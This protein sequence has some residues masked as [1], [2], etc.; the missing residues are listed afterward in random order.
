[1]MTDIFERKKS[2]FYH[3]GKLMR[4]NKI[5][6]DDFKEYITTRLPLN[7]DEKLYDIVEE[8][9]AF[10]NLHPYYTQQLSAQVWEM[11]TYDHL[12]DGVVKEAVSKIVRVHD[13]DFERLWLNFNRTDRSV[14]LSLSK[15]DN[16]LQ[17]RKVAS[18]TSFSAV[19]RLMKAGYVIRVTDYEIED[20]FF[21]EWVI[22]FCQ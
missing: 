6:Y 15:G 5:P 12:V 10:T 4:L 3:F 18:S 2:P 8:I 16:P 14:I 7:E 11:M 22:R 20:P 19:K 17:N 9:L 21:K 1:M 13:L